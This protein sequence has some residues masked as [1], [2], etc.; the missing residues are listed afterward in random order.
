MSPRP[1]DPRIADSPDLQRLAEEGYAL[2]IFDGHLLVHGVPY[3]NAARSVERGVLVSAINF[4]GEVAIQPETHVAYWIGAHPCDAQGQKLTKIENASNRLELGANL[5]VDHTFSAKPMMDASGRYATYYEKVTSYVHRI[6]G[7]AQA[8]DSRASACTGDVV[9]TRGDASVFVYTDTATARAGIGVLTQRLAAERVA[10]VGLGG[11]GAYILDQLAK[12]S[13]QEIHLFDHDTFVQS[14]AFRAPGAASIDEL[15]E[16]PSKVA[17]YQKKYSVMRRGIIPHA[18]A[19]TPDTVTALSGMSCIFI[20]VD[21]GTARRVVA[22]FAELQGIPLIDTGIG[23]MVSNDALIAQARVSTVTASHAA[24]ARADLPF[25]DRDDEADPYRTNIQTAD[26]NALNAI[27][28]VL[29]WKRLRGFYH[30]LCDEP[31]SIFD[32]ATNALINRV[33]V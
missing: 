12:T 4:A 2:E 10:I 3:V 31:T 14:T 25:G 30:D 11:T 29:R 1:T 18:Y 8:L 20:S 28:A 6:A 33:S 26:L 13:V 24:A 17:Y 23:M 22:D 32:V 21:R 27:L 9:E 19:I 7:P 15:R 16:R 5:T